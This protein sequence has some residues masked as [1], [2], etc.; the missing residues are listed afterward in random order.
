MGVYLEIAPEPYENYQAFISRCMPALRALNVYAHED[1]DEVYRDM[2]DGIWREYIMCN[3]VEVTVTM[4]RPV[5]RDSIYN[6]YWYNEWYTTEVHSAVLP[7]ITYSTVEKARVD[8][9]DEF[10]IAKSIKEKQMVFGWANVAKDKDGNFPIDWD[11][12]VT[13][14]EQL[15]NAAYS[16]V[17]KHRTTG[18]MHEGEAKGDLVESV[19]FTKEK[20]D[21]MGIPHGIVPE[22]WWV[23]FH[24]PDSDVFAKVKSG[25]Y[26]MWSVQGKGKRVPTGQ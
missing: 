2:A 25:E 19:M 18:E 26:G 20:M 8:S 23:G 21:A 15:E 5:D 24:I 1:S 11:G 4:K 6:D 7:T 17:L 13:L 9:G 3:A 14:P 12:D 10:K 22:G 16:F